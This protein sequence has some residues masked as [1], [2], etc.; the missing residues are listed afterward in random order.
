MHRYIQCLGFLSKEVYYPSYTN[1]TSPMR[2]EELIP[3][4]I[5]EDMNPALGLFFSPSVT[6][7][8]FLVWQTPYPCLKEPQDE[9]GAG[10]PAVTIQAKAA[11]S[12]PE[13]QQSFGL[14]CPPYR[15]TQHS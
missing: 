13:C 10:R 14:S 3:N 11:S 9:G 7:P 6:V 15:Q 1:I 5:I 2:R 12:I 8:G 4:L